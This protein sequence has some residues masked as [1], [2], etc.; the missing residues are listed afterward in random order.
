[1][2]FD[3]LSRV[4]NLHSGEEIP[5]LDVLRPPS[6]TRP[7]RR[8]LYLSLSSVVS[9]TPSSQALSTRPRPTGTLP[10]QTSGCLVRPSRVSRITVTLHSKQGV[11]PPWTPLLTC[12]SRKYIFWR[13]RFDPNSLH[14]QTTTSTEWFS[15]QD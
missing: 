3:Y 12:L 2:D 8:H 10:I 7:T 5:T 4:K 1:M 11:R 14:D 15:T 6:S 13:R 9:T